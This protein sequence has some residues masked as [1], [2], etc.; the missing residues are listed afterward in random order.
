MAHANPELDYDHS[1][2]VSE[3]EILKAEMIKEIELREEKAEAHKKLAWTAMFAILIFTGFIMSPI[4]PDSRVE[5]LSDVS[6]M[7]FVAQGTIV[8]AYFGFTT[9]MSKK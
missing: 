9:W 4:I 3:E 1:G 5:L 2:E 8:T 6:A 7:F